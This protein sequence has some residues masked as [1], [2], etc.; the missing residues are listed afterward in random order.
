M[1][2]LKDREWG[3]IKLDN[4][5]Q[6]HTGGD[7]IISRI[8][9]GN[10]P[11]ISHSKINNGVAEYTNHIKGRK[12]FD[13]SKSISLA[14]R[15]NFCA[16]VQKTDFYIGT[17]VKALVAKFKEANREILAFICT[18]IN[19][20]SI[21]FSY[22]NNATDY[23]GKITIL[24]PLIKRN[25][26]DWR[27]M[28]NYI[29]EREQIQLVEYIAHANKMFA[30]ISDTKIPVQLKEKEWKPFQFNS[31]F[32]EIKRGKRLKKS[33][34]KA[35]KQPYI[36]ST[37][38]N[39]G[40]DGFVS[41]V[42]RVRKFKDCLTI[43]NSGSVGST[44]YHKYEFVASDHVTQLKNV[45][46]NEYIYLFLLPIISRL[47]EKYSFNREINDTRINKEVLLLPIDEYGNP[48]WHYMEQFAKLIVAEKI[49]LYLDYSNRKIGV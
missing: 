5:F 21:R 26:P 2:S 44:F 19:S 7:L 45:D 46:F 1:L 49:K 39:N 31:I 35:G 28:E 41:N 17:R 27:F 48:D 8:E 18:L 16:Y 37:A 40:V 38:T 29:K 22:G 10:I 12:L 4:L 47:E 24:I 43:A 9:K 15:G 33:D 14:D 23:T 20:Q 11:I 3:T 36:S 34:H 42:D 30:E 25:E 6:I 13:S 32:S